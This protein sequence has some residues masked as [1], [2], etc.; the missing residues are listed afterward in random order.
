MGGEP[1]ALPMLLLAKMVG[2][3]KSWSPTTS[4]S[5]HIPHPCPSIILKPLGKLLTL[6]YLMILN[7]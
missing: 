1:M 6:K 2:A 5:P 4:G 3:E 7:T